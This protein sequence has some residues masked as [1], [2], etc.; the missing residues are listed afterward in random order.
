MSIIPQHYTVTE[1]WEGKLYIGLTFDW[2]YDQRRVHKS[3]PGY[4]DQEYQ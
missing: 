1:D 3:M 4:V 2:E